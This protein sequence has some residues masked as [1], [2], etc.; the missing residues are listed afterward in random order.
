[1]D[2]SSRLWHLCY[3]PISKTL[4]KETKE[5]IKKMLDEYKE[6]LWRFVLSDIDL[7][8]P[9]L[10]LQVGIGAEAVYRCYKIS[11]RN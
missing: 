4:E 1:M 9:L 11:R 3:F 8:C 7:N 5:V 2:L 10:P 6:R